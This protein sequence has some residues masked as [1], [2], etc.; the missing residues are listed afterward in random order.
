MTAAGV[1][2][3]VVVVKQVGLPSNHISHAEMT[4]FGVLVQFFI[5]KYEPKHSTTVKRIHRKQ[6]LFPAL[7]IGEQALPF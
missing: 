3:V 1:V 4:H 5:R 6:N 7:E 2:V